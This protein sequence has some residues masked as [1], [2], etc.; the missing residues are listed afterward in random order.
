MLMGPTLATFDAAH[1]DVCHLLFSADPPA[2]KTAKRTQRPC[3]NALK[4]GDKVITI[5]G[6]HGTIVDPAERRVTLKVSDTTKMVF[7]RD[8][9]M[10]SKVKTVNN[11]TVC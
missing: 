2:A 3:C 11:R 10:P 4:K 7:E 8:A 1:S 5:G 6:I 9:I